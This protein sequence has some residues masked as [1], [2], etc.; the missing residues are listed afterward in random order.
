VG[1]CNRP[2]GSGR[3][4]VRAAGHQCRAEYSVQHQ[5]II[6]RPAPAE[7]KTN[8]RRQ[9]DEDRQPRF[10]QIGINRQPAFFRCGRWVH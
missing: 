8:E 9:Q 4:R 6:H 1:G 2:D 5:Q 3:L 10:Y 7:I